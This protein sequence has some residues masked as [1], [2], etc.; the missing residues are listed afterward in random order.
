MR[1]VKGSGSYLE[2]QV[3]KNLAKAALSAFIFSVALGLLTFRLLSTFSLSALEELALIF[4]LAPLI[5]FYY[6]LWQ[7]HIYRSGWTGE[8]QV[9][10]LL[11]K[12]LSDDYLLIND[13]YLR[14]S[15]GD[16]DHIVLGPNAIF[17]LETKNWR[18]NIVCNGDQWQRSKKHHQQSSPSSQ[19]KRNVTKIH[20][21]IGSNPSLRLLNIW[22]EG[23]V[24]FTNSHIKLRLNNPTVSVLKLPQLPNY[25]TT[26]TR[27]KSFTPQQLE[28]IEKEIVKQKG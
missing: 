27:P 11:T 4:L 3:R 21:I 17:V 18:G 20:Q 22:V 13:L 1:K 5:A 12:T 26:F 10:K 6:Y 23:I 25:L 7:Y 2:N 19:V 16:I 24:V 14:N 28:V 8:K 15:Y 9:T